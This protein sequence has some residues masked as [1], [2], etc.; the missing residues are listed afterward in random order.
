MIDRRY[1]RSLQLF[2]WL[3]CGA[4]TVKLVFFTEYG[5]KRGRTQPHVFTGVRLLS[6]LCSLLSGLVSHSKWMAAGILQIQQYAD[7]TLDEFFGVEEIAKQAG[8]SKDAS[9]A[10]TTTSDR[11]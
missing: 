10:E 5:T 11:H 8:P 9:P 3:A 4:M 7:K 6:F 2:T 1:H